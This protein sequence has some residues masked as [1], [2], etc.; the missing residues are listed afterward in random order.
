MVDVH[1]DYRYM[2][3]CLKKR[4]YNS[5]YVGTQFGGSMYSMTDPFYMVMLI[6]NLGKDYIVWDKAGH[7]EFLRPGRT[8]LFAEFRIDQALI[9]E[10][11]RQTEA[12]SKY[13]FDLPVEIKDTR[14]KLIATVKKTLFVQRKTKQV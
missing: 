13:I 8:D 2:K 3:I 11:V 9:D 7:I 4:W 6:N 5:N 14:G 10:V 12:K 1:E